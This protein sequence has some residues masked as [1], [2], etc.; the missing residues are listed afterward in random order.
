MIPAGRLIG[1]AL[2]ATALAALSLWITRESLR[3]RESPQEIGL[4]WLKEEY[5]LDAAAFG[6][7][8]ALHDEYFTQCTKMCRQI[9]AA[10]RP[11]LWRARHRSREYGD[12]GVQLSQEQALC[13]DCEKA[14]VQHLQQVAVLMPPAEGKR[15]LDDVLPALQQQRREHERLVSSSLG[16]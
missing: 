8:R 1:F 15:F 10:A 7:I 11:L 5:L 16:R 14:A 6:R 3:P 13:G 9:A 12:V 4:R 2:I